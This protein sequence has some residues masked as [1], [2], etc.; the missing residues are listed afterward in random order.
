MKKRL[1]NYYHYLKL[2]LKMIYF[3]IIIITFI[4]YFVHYT[5]IVY[6]FMSIE[7]ANGAR[8]ISYFWD[9]LSRR[10]V[11]F[12]LYHHEKPKDAVVGLC[13]AHFVAWIIGSGKILFRAKNQDPLNDEEFYF[14][15][16][17]YSLLY[18]YYAKLTEPID[19]CISVMFHMDKR[20]F[21]VLVYGVL[22]FSWAYRQT[23]N[24]IA[25]YEW[26][27]GLWP[28]DKKMVVG[29]TLVWL[30][31]YPIVSIYFPKW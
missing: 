1:I 14:L 24:E 16:T 27:A 23:L 22:F 19:S 17:T 6:E 28:H 2:V 21:L 26:Y 13:A 20:D 30:I 15:V 11:D 5:Y 7:I 4:Y 9:D 3:L 8:R 31:A 10:I 25:V 18:L 29:F 12:Y